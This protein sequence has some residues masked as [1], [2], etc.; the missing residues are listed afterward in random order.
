[1]V[2]MT[3]SVLSSASHISR[4]RLNCFR[5]SESAS[6]EPLR[7]NLLR[8]T[9]SAASSISSFSSWLGA[10]YSRVVT[11]IDTSATSVMASSPWP[12]PLVSTS[13][14]SKP[15]D[16]Q[17]SIALPTQSAISLPLA[18]LANE[19][20][21]RCS[22]ESEFILILSPRSAPP[23][24]LRVGSVA[25]S[26]TLLP[27]LSRWTLSM[28][29]SIRLDLPAPPVPVSP[30]TGQAS[31][32]AH[33]RTRS[34]VEANVPSSPFSARVSSRA[35]A[36]WSAAVMGPVSESKRDSSSRSIPRAVSM[37]SCTMPTSPIWR[38]SSGE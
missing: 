8:T 3:G 26:A 23:V 13:T 31:S 17:A 16:W 19:R 30:T 29:S 33:E 21:N 38:P 11:Y 9:M 2:G 15:T 27:G 22:S 34:R 37:A 1:M 32:S 24:R 25:S 28:I 18:R 14:R 7:S 6:S 36:P 5:I 20:M 35:T 12:M 10:P 4:L